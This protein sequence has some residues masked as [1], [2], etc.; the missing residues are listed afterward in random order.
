[1]DVPNSDITLPFQAYEVVSIITNAT[2]Q[3]EVMIY[4]MVGGSGGSI[5]LKVVRP[6]LSPP[7]SVNTTVA[8]GCSAQSFQSALSSFNS[9]SSYGMS[10]ERNIYDSN[11]NIINT[12]ASASKIDY[13]VSFYLLRPAA[14][15]AEKFIVSYLNY[16]GLFV[17]TPT[18]SHSDLING[19]WGLTIGNLPI[20]LA[21]SNSNLPYNI[22]ASTLQAALQQING[23]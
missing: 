14:Y 21:Q 16:T 10:V 19:T 4:S 3:S 15:Q 22:G 6:S 2:V 12:T 8:Y 18:T 1:V 13:V 20:A 23:Y 17:T 11:N 7:Y 5:N 9:F